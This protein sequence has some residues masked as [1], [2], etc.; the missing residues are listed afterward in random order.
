MPHLV[1][2]TLDVFRYDLGDSL[3]LAGDASLTQRQQFTSQLSVPIASQLDFNQ[4]G[5]Y[6]ELFG[7]PRVY[8]FTEADYEGYYYP[9]KMG[10]S[11]GLLLNASRKNPPAG[12]DWQWV[13][14]L[15]QFVEQQVRGHPPELGPTWVFYASVPEATLADYET[16]AQHCYH[17]LIPEDQRPAWQDAK[18]GDSE[19]SGGKWFEW[20]QHGQYH[21][22]IMLFAHSAFAAQI[23]PKLMVDE[24]R[25]FEYRHKNT[26]AYAQSRTLKQ[27]L[28]AKAVEIQACREA[29]P[30]E[31][32]LVLLKNAN[33]VLSD[34]LSLLSNLEIQGHT[35][36]TNLY[37]YQTR[38][39]KLPEKLVDFNLPPVFKQEVE[40]KYLRQIRQ[41]H[42]SFSEATDYHFNP[43]GGWSNLTTG[44][45]LQFVVDQFHEMSQ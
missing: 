33:S 8:Q 28:K 44:E 27:L 1:Y 11:Y 30:E 10:D 45:L 15:R 21:L 3:G 31:A 26:W 34:Y 39:T 23:V 17:A 29:F 40:E 18:I 24:M 19:F 12:E 22:V 5:D 36:E 9:V 35:I 16:I 4:T 41:D 32:P 14:E 42:A 13:T 6:V 37:N 38:L 43:L 7:K 2:P 25:L 20:Y